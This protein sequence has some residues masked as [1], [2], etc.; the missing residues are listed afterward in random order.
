MNKVGNSRLGRM[1]CGFGG[2]LPVYAV[3]FLGLISHFTYLTCLALPPNDG[4]QAVL[5]ESASPKPEASRLEPA[6]PG[7]RIQFATNA[8][9]LGRIA[10]GTTV[11]C[12]FAFTN[13]GQST[14][15]IKDVKASCGCTTAGHWTRSVAP[16]AWGIIPLQLEAPNV[17]TSFSKAVSISCND[18]TQPQV[19]LALTGAFWVAVDIKP[20]L[21]SFNFGDAGDTNP[22]K[23]VRLTSRLKEPL[24]PNH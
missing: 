10:G 2:S 4:G 19:S 23:T 22:I 9:A 24:T 1:G 5:S 13:T 8:L 12:D 21:A 6:A 7:P 17:D 16:G 20:P 15:E 3:R 18:P 14:L 11:R